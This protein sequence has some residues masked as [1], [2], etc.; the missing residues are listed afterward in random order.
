VNITAQLAIKMFVTELTVNSWWI[1]YQF[2]VKSTFSSYQLYNTLVK[3]NRFVTVFTQ[4]F[5]ELR[6]IF[7][8]RKIAHFLWITLVPKC[9][10]KIKITAKILQNKNCKILQVRKTLLAIFKEDLIFLQPLSY[11]TDNIHLLFMYKMLQNKCLW[12]SSSSTE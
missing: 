3:A 2:D 6:H 1:C 11:D 7:K 8:L 9:G 4:T 10:M 5:H 12:I